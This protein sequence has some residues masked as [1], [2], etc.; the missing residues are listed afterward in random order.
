MTAVIEAERDGI[1]QAIAGTTVCSEFLRTVSTQPDA[2]A[3]RW[4]EGST[5]A[6]MTWA[7]YADRAARVAAGLQGLGVTGG[8]RVALFTRNRPEFHIADMGALFAGATPLSLYNSSPPAQIEYVL[9][10]S[11][12]TVV[13]AE[14][15]E[16]AGRIASVR[17]SLPALRHVVV[18]EP[19]AGSGGDVAFGDLLAGAPLDVDA[20]A[21]RIDSDDLLT[22]IYTSGTT[23]PPKGVMLTHHNLRYAVEIY[24]QRMPIPLRGL[25]QVSYLPMAHIAERLAT[26][27]FHVLQ[28]S[29]V[30]TCS[31]LTALPEYMVDV[32]PQWWFCAPRLWERLQAGAQA[33]AGP[34]ADESAIRAALGRLGLGEVKV[35]VTGSAPLPRSTFEFFRRL[36]IPLADCYGQ[37]ETSGFVSWDPDDVVPGTSGKP[38]AGVE[39]RI[40]GDGEIL[41]RGPNVFAG[42]LDE[43]KRSAEV[44]EADG[45]LHTGDLGS[46]D[47]GGN[48]VVRGRKQEMLVPSTGHNVSPVALEAALKELPLVR[49]ACA[50]GDGRPFIAAVVVL[51]P[52]VTPGWAEARGIAGSLEELAAHPEVRR[53]V[54][55]GVERVNE[56]FA[57][58]EQIRAFALVG[59]EWL[60]DSDVLT[61][62]SKL[63]RAAVHERYAAQI[64]ELYG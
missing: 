60:P 52:E 17:D 5:F 35:A 29:V 6:S 7:E 56:R 44:L 27:Y 13:V 14:N 22:V 31:D 61:P 54:E 32:Q 58:P 57:R 37:S 25:R 55:E 62:T 51:D 39:V 28:G 50:V 24:A 45:W 26:H 15:D 16:F 47:D 49:E 3:L 21:A 9:G 43:P 4:K 48:L 1:E 20:A 63:K 23:G 64:V 42:Y 10:H 19:G 30:T 12:A 59:D 46:L 36:G 34:D 18:I 38:F 33:M 41:V 2:A 40:A 11:R 53:E 8:E